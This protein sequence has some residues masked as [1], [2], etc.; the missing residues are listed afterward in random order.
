MLIEEQPRTARPGIGRDVLRRLKA[1]ILL[2]GSLRN[3]ELARAT[4]RSILDL[5][6]DHR[7]TLLDQWRG[8]GR[9]LRQHYGH[10]RLP[11]R[12]LV[13]AGT[14]LPQVGDNDNGE[15]VEA[16]HDPTPLRGTGGLLHDVA[17]DYEDDDWIFVAA[18]HQ[19]LTAP[20]SRIFDRLLSSR[21]QVRLLGCRDGTPCSFMLI[22]CAALRGI[23]PIGFQDLKEQALP[24]IARDH[25]VFVTPMR[26]PPSYPIR[27][28]EG[29]LAAVQW[30]L[31]E[32][33]S[34]AALR[35]PFAEDTRTQFALIS[36]QAAV[37]PS[38]TVYNSVIL[39]GARVENDAVVLRSIVC[40]RAVVRARQEVIDGIVT[41]GTPT[42]A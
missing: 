18:A 21:G 7:T 13:N 1:V 14:P 23:K 29:Y 6:L 5:P 28:R 26:Q 15:D 39:P 9:G 11:M 8:E 36:D 42:S 31:A 35:D 4:R 16:L 38:A 27:D 2:A 25:D 41:N 37:A 17:A 3:N 40:A 12:I 22:Q 24:T 19:A 32:G 34:R 10:E 30:K 20:L 33:E